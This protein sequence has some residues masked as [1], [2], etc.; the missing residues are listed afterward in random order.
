MKK[1]AIIKLRVLQKL[2]F[3]AGV[4]LDIFELFSSQKEKKMRFF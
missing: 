2:L 3:V 1:L 4:I